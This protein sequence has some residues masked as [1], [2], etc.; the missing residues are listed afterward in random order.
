M[1]VRPSTLTWRVTAQ[2]GP[3]RV[4]RQAVSD[5][6]GPPSRKPLISLPKPL[7]KTLSVA[8]VPIAETFRPTVRRVSSYDTAAVPSGDGGRFSTVSRMSSGAWRPAAARAS[9][10]EPPPAPPG[11]NA[12]T[13]AAR[14][15][16][17]TAA[18][19]PTAVLRRPVRGGGPE[20]PSGPGT[21]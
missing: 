13:P 20:E 6:S 18:T 5:A 12:H 19:A 17:R 1:A 4:S 10:A 9:D 2:S 16:S 3:G 11:P 14:A 8:Q 21:L 15:T 7:A